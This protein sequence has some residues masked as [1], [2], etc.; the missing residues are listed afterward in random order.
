MPAPLLNTALRAGPT[1][2]PA[3][4]GIAP[5]ACEGVD[6]F[7]GLP[8]ARPEAPISTTPRTGL[9]SG[10]LFFQ[11][12][13]KSAFFIPGA[14]YEYYYLLGGVKDLSGGMRQG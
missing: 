1:F 3:I 5:T 6:F 8:P 10:I 7:Y 9:G 14:Y 13:R 12:F 4:R 11:G 2:P